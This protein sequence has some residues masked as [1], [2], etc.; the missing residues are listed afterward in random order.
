MDE[1]IKYLKLAYKEA[2]KAYEL[3]EVPVGCV[4]VTSVIPVTCPKVFVVICG[5]FVADHLEV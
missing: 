2:L 3:D 5:T 4:I 1:D